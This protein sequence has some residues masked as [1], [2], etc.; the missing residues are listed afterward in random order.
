MWEAVIELI[1]NLASAPQILAVLLLEGTRIIYRRNEPKQVGPQKQIGMYEFVI[2]I[3]N[4]S[5]NSAPSIGL[6]VSMFYVKF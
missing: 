1:R 5:L 4:K 3:W 2:E 6:I